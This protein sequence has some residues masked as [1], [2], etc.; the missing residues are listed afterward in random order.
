[1]SEYARY[2]DDSQRSFARPRT[3]AQWLHLDLVLLLPLCLIM[4]LGLFVLF[5]ASD[6]DWSTV[7]RQLRNFV[8]GWG[9]LL[10]VAQVR[11]DTIQRWSPALYFFALGLLL[12]VLMFGVG[13]KGAQRWLSLG[14]IRFQPSEVMKIAMPLAVAYWVVRYGL[15]PRLGVTVVSLL[16]IGLPAV[17]IGLQPDLGTALLV[18]ASGV[19]VI[20]MAGISWWQIMAG[21]LT[22]LAALWPA[23]LFILRD[24]QKQRILTLFDPEA[25][26]LGAGWNI[27]QSK[28]AIGSGGWSGKGWLQGT[29][30]HLDFLPESQTDFIIAVLAEEWGFRGVLCLLALY[31]LVVARGFWISLTAQST[32]GRL[33]ASAITLTFCVYVV[34]N[35]G[36]VAGLLPVVGVPLPFVSF[37][38][39]AIVTLMLG[40]GILTAISTEKRIISQ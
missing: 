27:I 1:M 14:I 24:Y 29:Q 28:T 4:V 8:V 20:F 5:S 37:G 39:T 6:G 15:P 22:A 31:G 33:L 16:I 17:V 2:L 3:L 19:S 23:W 35:M 38:G 13:A 40:F 30:S 36:M 32:Y 10:V 26:K 12:M 21:M 34:V 25:D 18:A 7:S 9:V 11:I